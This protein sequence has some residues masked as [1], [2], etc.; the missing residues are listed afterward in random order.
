VATGNLLH[1][2]RILAGLTRAQASDLSGIRLEEVEAIESSGRGV[3]V[4]GAHAL[5]ALMRALASAGVEF[6]DGEAPGVRLRPSRM[7]DGGI[8]VEDLNAGNDD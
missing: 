3:A 7:S 4:S 6:I 2:A 8:R 1:A 5:T